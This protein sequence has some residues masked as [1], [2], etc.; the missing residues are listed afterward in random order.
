M[1]A[2]YPPTHDHGFVLHHH[3]NDN[4]CLFCLFVPFDIPS[5]HCAHGPKTLRMMSM[6]KPQGR[7]RKMVRDKIKK[8]S[9]ANSGH[10][11]NSGSYILCF[12][13][14]LFINICNFSFSML[15]LND[16]LL[17]FVFFHQ[18]FTQTWGF[19]L[20]SVTHQVI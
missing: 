4:T 13:W 11:I 19:W 5:W 15:W 2:A 16:F 7:E 6:T 10:L 12:L 20:Y 17:F 14:T 8:C 18:L 3:S 1:G 9:P